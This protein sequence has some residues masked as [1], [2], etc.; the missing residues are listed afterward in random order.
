[1]VKEKMKKTEIGEIP[2]SWGINPFEKSIKKVKI[3]RNIKIPKSNYLVCGQF[4]IVDQGQNFISGWTNDSSLLFKEELPV[5]I[6]GDHTRIFKYID[7][8]F[9]LGADGTKLIIPTSSYD[10]RFFY[11]FLLNQSIRSIGYSRHYSL[12]KEILVISP[13][14]SEQ[15]AI[16]EVL[17]SLDD[18]IDL[19]HRQNKTLEDTA[20]TLFRKWFI[21]DADERWE[22][23][24]LDEVI[25]INPRYGLKKGTMA[26]YLS[27]SN[28]NTNSH[29]P[30]NWYNRD[31][32]SGMQF[33]NGDT[34]FARITPSLEN[35][36]TCFIDFLKE[37][38]IG[39]GSTEY[40]V[41]RSK[42]D[43]PPFLSYVIAK[44]NDF[45]NYAIGTMTGTSGRQRAQAKDLGKYPIYIPPLSILE[46]F[47]RQCEDITCKLRN[48]TLRIR[49]LNILRDTLLPKLINGEI[50]VVA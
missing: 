21:E 12:L 25:D 49:T 26:P 32:Q 50:R 40:I 19:L 47:N 15:K 20:Q 17:G 33:K 37:D 41:M 2:E 34:L 4:P 23:K 39:W 36:K 13:P 7:E 3:K 44:N 8:P 48:N 6:F 9:A 43:L 38:E 30:S 28:I 16:A 10:T 24:N 27:M 35:G 46:K 18:K 31:F 11:Y 42:P 5:I 1:M 22:K 29:T 14:L 45:R